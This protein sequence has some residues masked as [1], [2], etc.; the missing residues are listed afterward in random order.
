MSGVGKGISA[1]SMAKILQF[2]NLKVTAV[3]IDPYVN[4]DAGT[5][6]P[7][8][9]GEVFVLNDGYE[10]DQDMGNYE[11]FLDT[12]LTSKNYMTTGSV[13]LKVINK[14]R[15]LGY[16][17]KC[18]DVVPHVP[19]SIIEQIEEAGKNENADV[20]IIEIGGTLGEYQNILFLEAAR[21]LKNK[22][23]DDVIYTLVSFLPTPN[24]IGEMK[25]KPTQYAVRTMQ[26]TGLTPDIIIGRSTIAM[27]KK[28]KEK[29]SFSC[30][31]PKENIISAPDVSSIYDVPQIF[32]NEKLDQ[33]LLKKLNIQKTQK[34][35]TKIKEWNNF[36]KS[37]KKLK[38]E[39]NIAII[40]KYFNT[41]DFVLSD[42]YI[43]IIE[44][45]K[46]SAYKNKVKVNLKWIN[47]TVFEE[48]NYK[49]EL[50]E[51]KKYDGILIPGGFGKTGIEGK[52]TAI[53]FIRENK[54]PFFGICYGL[55][56]AAIEFA[57]NVCGIKKA[58]SYE[59]D[60]QSKHQIVTILPEQK[61]LLEAGDYG[62]SMR[63]GAYPA[64]IKKKTLAYKIYKDENISERH[65]HRYELND[66]YLE[67]LQEKGLIISAFSAREKLPEIIELP[68]QVHP[69]F[70]AT[71]F[72]PEMQ[73]RPL[74]THPIFDAFI[75]A[76]KKQVKYNQEK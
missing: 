33:I 11:R 12:S 72:H 55:Q 37:S 7:T 3:K 14:E 9:H 15:S 27:D 76:S 36:V 44:A 18:V 68:T 41:G 10:C 1:S 39:I 67:I 31:I 26:Q 38:K 71:Q 69:F 25:T 35:E 23:P 46:F 58:T 32:L 43:S 29:I 34:N 30:S 24:K 2:H 17:G 50:N 13:Y 6:N 54:I 42:A 61:K 53:K 4:V 40:G 19:L 52:I 57:R 56:L 60:P 66:E 48:K 16:K 73:A 65:R 45:L 21:I 75:K 49:K 20:V 28:R 74:N 62:G 22:N 63:L 59:I 64:T 5:M 51:L 70:I 8:E 47:S